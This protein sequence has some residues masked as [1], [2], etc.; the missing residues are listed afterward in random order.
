[1]GKNGSLLRQGVCEGTEDFAEVQL[2]GTSYSLFPASSISPLKPTILGSPP[3]SISYA[4]GAGHGHA[5]SDPQVFNSVQSTA[6]LQ[7]RTTS[8]GHYTYRLTGVGDASYPLN[9][10]GASLPRARG[11]V[12][13]QQVLSRPTASFKSTE[14]LSYCLSDPF[15]Q[16]SHQGA[17]AVVLLTGQAPF[18][19]AL[20]VKNVATNEAYHET[21]DVHSHEWKGE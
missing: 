17:E 1:M 6:R 13:E 12:L 8:S 10:N 19:L 9:R 4:Y 14:R 11:L 18:K 2:T 7:L 21:F 20:S 3:F 5:Q 16:K 15:V